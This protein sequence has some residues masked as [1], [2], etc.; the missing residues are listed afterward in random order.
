MFL[1]SKTRFCRLN[2]VKLNYF[3]TLNRGNAHVNITDQ[4]TACLKAQLT[5]YALDLESVAP[6]RG[7]EKWEHPGYTVN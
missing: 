7:V 4:S 1:N 6:Q 2:K 3:F 5:F